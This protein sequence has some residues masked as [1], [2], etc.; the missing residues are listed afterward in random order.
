MRTSGDPAPVPP[1][2]SMKIGVAALCGTPRAM[3]LA[4]GA[5]PSAVAGTKTG[6]RGASTAAVP[7]RGA[8]LIPRRRSQIRR[9]QVK[10]LRAEPER[11]VLVGG[12]DHR[13]AED[14]VL[15]PGHALDV[16]E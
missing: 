2:Q 8:R 5:A 9:G 6:A 1:V 16:V 7:C 14:P 13:V 3:S 11:R 10:P 15:P 12:H 4:V